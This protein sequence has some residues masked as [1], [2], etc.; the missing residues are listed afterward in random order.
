MIVEDET[1]IAMYIEKKLDKLGYD[2]CGWVTSGEEA[3]KKAAELKP[4]LILMD[5]F[6]SGDM[7]G[8]DTAKVIKE[9]LAI[10]VIYITGNADFPTISRARETDPYGYVLKPINELYLYS[11]IDTAFHRHE[12]EKRLIEKEGKYRSLTDM[13]TDIVWI[14]DTDF[15]T[16][17]VSPSITKMLGYTPEERCHQNIQGMLTPESLSV[18]RH[19]LSE[20]LKLESTGKADPDRP[21]TVELE[22]LHKDGTT[23][24]VENIMRWVRDDQGRIAGIHGVS[25]DISDRKKY[26]EAFQ[27]SEG[28]FRALVDNLQ[29]IILVVD[30]EGNVIYENPATS[31][32][33]GYSLLGTNGF[34]IIHPD[35]LEKAADD[36]TEAIMKQNPHIPTFFR[37]KKHDGSWIHL[38]VL[39]TNMIDDPSIHGI[40]LVCHD[41]TRSREA[42]NALRE[43]EQRY[44]ALFHQSPV[45]IFMFDPELV[46]TDCNDRLAQI[47]RSKREELIGVDLHIIRQNNVVSLMKK[48]L[49]GYDTSYE[50]PYNITLVEGFL[51]V[52]VTASPLRNEAGNVIG[53]MGVIEDITDRYTAQQSLKASEE[54][55]RMLVENANESIT[56]LKDRR[57]VFVNPRFVKLTGYSAEYLGSRDFT[58]FIHP[59]DHEKMLARYRERIQGNTAPFIYEARVVDREGRVIWVELNSVLFTWEGEQAILLFIRDISER[60][61]V[62][63]ERKRIESQIQ[64]TQKLESLGVLAG[65]IAHDFNNL[66]MTILGNIDIAMHESKLAPYQNNALQE[67]AKASQRA[68]E[69]CQQMLAYSG[70]GHFVVRIIDLYDTIEDMRHMLEIFV[71]K[72][73]DL[74]FDLKKG[75]PPIEADATQIR[76]GIMNLIINAS[77]AIG[78]RGG[79]ISLE[80]GTAECDREYLSDILLNEPL[81][82]GLYVYL[83]VKDDGC[84]MDPGIITK[85]FD[86]FFTTKFPGRGLGL[87]A[88]LGIVRGHHG[89]IKIFSE[90]GKGTTFKILFPAVER[91][92]ERVQEIPEEKKEWRGSGTVL[93]VDD[94]E[95]IRAVAGRMLELL[96]FSVLTASNGR[97][98][99]DIFKV[100]NNDIS[101]V[102][103]DLTMPKMDGD[104]AFR[105]LKKIK[106]DVCVI[107]SSGYNELEITSRFLDDSPSGFIQKPYLLETLA[108]K[109][110]EVLGRVSSG[111]N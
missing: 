94:E 9:T 34:D 21:V 42:E 44:Q 30:H 48:T 10:P 13:M 108:A 75:L 80:T 99:V 89:A 11:M 3:I 90:E 23:V 100:R 20:E 109:M 37:A 43:S 98:A 51:W 70:K 96:G 103:L 7:D 32:L 77:D 52:N 46:L 95:N 53:G 84:G 31:E 110:K 78:E 66:L 22:Y 83:E 55:N 18:I 105:E 49:Q 58:D 14:M 4:G 61:H 50:G 41:V 93:L 79:T 92:A 12:L 71:S 25:R 45:G 39:A 59:D 65:G 88:V 28:R 63:E 81:P 60:K 69:L 91:G 16:T 54:R 76:Q 72:K 111:S 87:A 86:P 17:Y 8:I 85:I 67:A 82:E 74:T 62:E 68:A 106:K 47:M 33:L 36:F 29:D 5:I 97:E 15:R 107:M 101:C 38:S 27:K 24:W 64:Q 56:V 2:V 40:L 73:A 35:D 57:F 104:E 19:R 1:A 6:L 26:D 102:I